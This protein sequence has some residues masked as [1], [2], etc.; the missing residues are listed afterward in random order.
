MSEF[1]KNRLAQDVI[2][3]NRSKKKLWKSTY[4]KIMQSKQAAMAVF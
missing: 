4:I 1:K 2:E 3:A